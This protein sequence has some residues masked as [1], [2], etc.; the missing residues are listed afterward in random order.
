MLDGGRPRVVSAISNHPLAAAAAGEVIGE[1]LDGVGMN[2]ELVLVFAFG[3]HVD[4]VGELSASVTHVLRPRT[5]VAVTG[6]ARPGSGDGHGDA[7]VFAWATTVGPV[8]AVV[9]DET[10]LGSDGRAPDFG[11]SPA[12]IVA[13]GNAPQWPP[14][15]ALDRWSLRFPNTFITGAQPM[16][17]E[18]AVMV[19]GTRVGPG[20]VA[21]VFDAT[22]PL[23][24]KCVSRTRGVG[25][26]MTAN[27]VRGRVISELDGTDA[28]DR[29]ERAVSDL[30]PADRAELRREILIG[31]TMSH[32]DGGGFF[33][34]QLLGMNR[35]A[36]SLVADH[37]IDEGSILQ[38]QVMSD[39]PAGSILL[40]PFH[41]NDPRTI[42]GTL[43][44]ID[45]RYEPR[46]PTDAISTD[47]SR[48]EWQ[49]ILRR[50]L[51]SSGVIGS[52]G[53]R[54]RIQQHVVSALIV[55]RHSWL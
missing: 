7:G 1:V 14:Q 2:P 45:G 18:G 52:L 15:A 37:E 10:G 50:G 6:Q 21:L 36:G 26:S 53:G 22:A 11:P 47:G 38:L 4:F 43:T 13:F 34:A 20:G 39:D 24:G 30:M 3:G 32:E 8:R 16:G 51:C 5:T 49:D 27:V 28:I 48:D 35:R 29:F 23:S 25:P 9:L 55:G 54:T 40:D 42:V 12:A 41:R 33:V 19:G 46:D 17:H 44:F 31:V